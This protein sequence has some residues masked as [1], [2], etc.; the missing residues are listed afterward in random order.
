MVPSHNCDERLALLPLQ[1]RSKALRET[2]DMATT[3]LSFPNS[4]PYAFQ[5]PIATTAL[6]II[7]M[8]RDFL[9]PNGFGYIQCGN[10]EIFSSVRKI[11][12]TVRKAL[13]AARSIGMHVIHTRE[14]HRPDL[15]D[16]PAAKK[17]RQVSA[18][19]GHHAMGIGDQGPM[20]R[21]LVRGEWGH[22]VIDELTPHPGEIVIDKPGK[23][24][25]WGTGLHRM[26]LARGITHLLFS[27]VTT[28]CCVTTTLRECNDR[29]YECCILSDCT[30]GFDQ[31]MVT[32][33][34]D[35]ICGQDGLFGYIGHSSDFLSQVEQLPKPSAPPGALAPD[36][37]LPSVSELQRLY[38]HGLVDP[39]AVVNLVFDK[40]DKYQATDPAVWISKQARD[41]VLRAAAALSA[42]YAGKPLSPLFGVPFAVKDSIDV[43]GIVTT[44][45]CESF[46][47][48]ATS[49]APCIQHLL[50]A[51]ALYIGKTNLDQLATGLSGC[52]SPYG[53]PHSVYSNRHISG[54][55]S[56]GSGVAVAA[57]LVSFAVGTDTAG[58][59]RVPAALNGIVGF[60][61]T[62]GTISARGLVPA[63]KSLDAITVLAP[64]IADA[65]QVWHIIDRHD[66][67]DPYAKTPNSLSTW[68]VDFRGPEEGGF[69]FGI[70]PSSLLQQCSKA[71]QDLFKAAVEKLQSC[72]GRLIDIDFTPFA[73]AGDL[74]Y[75][76]TLVHER[77]ASIGHDFFIK[78]INS[79]HPTTKALY[80]SALST[81]LK[82]WQ[83]FNDQAAQAQYTMQ[84]RNTFDTLEGGIDVLVVPSVPCHPTIEEM[85]GDPI[86]LNSRLGMFTHAANVVDMCGVSVN[87]GFV[88]VEQGVK[89]PFGVTI[90]GGS[91]YDGKVLDIA[92]V[93]EACIEETSRR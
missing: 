11:V 84:A 85:S 57:G 19:N 79:L 78:N 10:P 56:S 35:I 92:A 32:T 25:F 26:L 23:G 54:G 38:K 22:D 51:G 17:L 12:P 60:K 76:A 45:A 36:V 93:F 55:S 47:Y 8:Q 89:L 37:E 20:G 88:E 67:L 86:A 66:S 46:A 52:R 7:D 31:Q 48:T 73:K 80:E 16:L 4:R 2:G 90:L 71:Y 69:T 70:P 74:L 65:R 33:S 29:G 91:G 21:L 58:S 77:L 3:K 62:K 43:A 41:D 9:D 63:C 24:S 82:P 27:G 1:G 34:L 83:V 72:G 64:C 15:S 6:I 49:T 68:K 30:G 18:P 39:A 28:E 53:T 87:A 5:C 81:H 44:V 14:G 13:D 75:D 42:E 61:P 40:I 50:A 59:T